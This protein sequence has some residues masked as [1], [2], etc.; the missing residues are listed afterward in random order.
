M[1]TNKYFQ[2]DILQKPF[3]KMY[4]TKMLFIE[5]ITNIIGAVNLMRLHVFFVTQYNEMVSAK[6][7]FLF[8]IMQL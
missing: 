8:F 6:I 1:R 4:W 5:I 3:G 2:N 7:C